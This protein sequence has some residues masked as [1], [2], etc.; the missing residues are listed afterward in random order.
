MAKALPIIRQEIEELLDNNI[1]LSNREAVLGFTIDGETSKDLDDALWIEPNQSGAV[2][3]VHISDVSAIIQPGSSLE[4]NALSQVETRYLATKNKPMFPHEL[5]EDK[6]SLLEDKL[7]LT[8]TIRITLDESANIKNTSL[9]LTHLTSLNRFSYSTA[10]ATLHDPSSPFFQMLR[11]CELWSQKLAWKRKDVGAIGLSRVGGVNLDEE[12]RILTSPL[13]HSQQIIQEFMIL[14]NTAVASLAEKHRLPMLYRNHTA[15]AIAPKSKELIETLTTLGL[16][17]LVRQKL[18]SW[19]NPAT[20]SPA[21]IGHFALAL[22]AYTHFTS[23]IRRVADYVNHRI[24]KAVFIEGKESP[25]TLEEL[26]AIANH[27]N[28]KRTQVKEL[29]DEH[30]REKRLNQT[31]NILRD[32][33]KIENLSDKEF[34]QIVKDSLRVS[35]LDKIVP[36][37]ISRI[38]QGNIKPVDL[39]YLIFGD[40]NNLDNKELLKNSILDYLEEKQV[41]ATQIIQIAG[42]TNQTTVEYI[43]KTTASGKFAFWSVLEGETTATPGIASNKQAAKHQANYLLIEGVLDQSLV[44]P[45]FI[46]E[47][48]LHDVNSETNI[49]QTVVTDESIPDIE[50]EIDF[51]EVPEEAHESQARLFTRSLTKTENETA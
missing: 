27:I 34:S 15:S 7:R 29:R 9:H 5:S 44:P 20:Y 31:V 10:D 47:S 14:A 2:V 30:F 45:E 8:V 21:V 48:S 16:P 42:T 13:Y 12:G 11:Y 4:A 19:L 3:S 43:E 26:Q 36:E 41:E 6:L 37:A 25:Y 46:D 32:K 17:E 50:D 18:Q 23:P 33:D 22:P 51:L 28:S 40:Y 38:E 24:L 1:S 35:K 39:Y 49:A